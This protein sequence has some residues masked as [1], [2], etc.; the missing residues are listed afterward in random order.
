MAEIARLKLGEG[1]LN[2][3]AASF[4]KNGKKM[5]LLWRN[6]Q[7]CKW[8]YLSPFATLRYTYICISHIFK[9]IWSMDLG[10]RWPSQRRKTTLHI[11]HP[12][13]LMNA[14][15]IFILIVIRKVVSVTFMLLVL[16]VECFQL[17]LLFC[18]PFRFRSSKRNSI[19]KNH[20]QRFDYSGVATAENLF[21]YCAMK[22]RFFRR[23]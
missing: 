6:I 2:S 3:F 17:N 22:K 12:K 13:V 21:L 19:F 15:N 9:W 11:H 10:L 20:H 8:N 14:R 1:G 5:T 7:L 18:R 23:S 4:L 16:V